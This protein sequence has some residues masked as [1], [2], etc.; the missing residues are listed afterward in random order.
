MTTCQFF[1]C[2]CLIVAAYVVFFT[3]VGLVLGLCWVLNKIFKNDKS[4]GTVLGR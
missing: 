4:K 2:L 3:V 1:L